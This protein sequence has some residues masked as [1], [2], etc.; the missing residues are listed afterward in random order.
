M[1]RCIRFDDPEARQQKREVSNNP[2]EE[3]RKVNDEFVKNCLDNYSPG[4][5]G[6]IV[7]VD[8]VK[9]YF[10]TWRGNTIDILLLFL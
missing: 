2:L 8:M 9:L 10:G 5:K 7:E 3:I 6:Q 4:T 1:F